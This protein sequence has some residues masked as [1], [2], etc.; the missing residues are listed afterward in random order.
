[1][2]AAG[3]IADGRGIAA[4]LMLGADGVWLG[5]RFIATREAGVPDAYRDRVVAAGADDTVLTDAFDAAAG[6]PWPEGVSG[7]AI[8]NDFT[9]TWDGREDE[10]R[11]WTDRERSAHR[12][13]ATDADVEQQ[14]VWAGEAAS[15]V[16]GVESAGDVVARL[17]AETTEVLSRRPVSV[18]RGPG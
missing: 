11:A 17:V 12:A 13:S 4:A 5:T 1:V 9:R 14:A 15:L 6:R 3:G 18:L 10:L 8:A 16:T 2:V 7:R